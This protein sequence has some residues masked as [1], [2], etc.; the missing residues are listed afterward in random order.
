[1]R[2]ESL[3]ENIIEKIRKELISIADEQ[4]KKNSQRFFKERVKTY[5]IKTW[6]VEKIAK[7]HWLDVEPLKKK[8]ILVLCEELFASG[9]Q[10]ESFVAST[11]LP[12]MVKQFEPKD[13]KIFERWVDKYVDNWAKCDTFCNHTVGDFIMKF[14]EKISELKKWARSKNR[15]MKRA[16]AVTLIVPARK[17][18]FLKDIFEIADVLLLDQDDMVQKG[19]GWMLKAASQ[20]HQ[21][22][23]LRFVMERKDRMPRTALRYAIEKMPPKMRKIAMDLK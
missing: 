1:M 7:R 14:P 19:Y 9:Y 18:L 11:W 22:E 16:S 6:T 15:W 4:V 3:M 21:K 10:E 2:Q 20:A 13:L 17:G 8:E 12:K 5:G 23:V